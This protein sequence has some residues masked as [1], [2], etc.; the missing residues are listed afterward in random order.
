MAGLS[1]GDRVAS[2]ETTVGEVLMT[3]TKIY[4]RPVRQVL[5]HYKVKNVVHGIA[6]VTGGG[7]HENLE[8]ILPENAQ[9]KIR[10]DA[11]TVPPVFTWLQQ[12]GDVD[13]DEMFRVFNMGIGLAMIVSPYFA[14][15]IC[16][17]WQAAGHSCVPI[18]IVAE[19]PRGV[20]WD[21]A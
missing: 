14:D 3:P 5:Q 9:V 10:K 13:E 17:M 2:L 19:G 8:R 18:G 4:A 15:S 12:L 6:H 20:I 21:G 7:L 11:W 1:V 16:R